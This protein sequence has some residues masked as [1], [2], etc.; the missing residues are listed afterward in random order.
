MTLAG[1]AIHKIGPYQE[2]LPDGT[3]LDYGAR[4]ERPKAATIGE[5]RKL[6]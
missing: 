3:K 2:Q 5:L 6:Q 4:T 1:W